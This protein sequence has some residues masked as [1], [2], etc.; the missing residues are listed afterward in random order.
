MHIYDRMERKMAKAWKNG[1]KLS[2]WSCS[3]SLETVTRTFAKARAS[4]CAAIVTRIFSSFFTRQRL[5]ASIPVSSFHSFQQ[6]FVP[7]YDL[8]A[9]T[10]THTRLNIDF[11]FFLFFASIDITSKNIYIRR[12]ILTYSEY[13]WVLL[14][15]LL[16]KYIS[17]PVD[18][19]EFS[20]LLDRQYWL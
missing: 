17:I 5:L 4:K 16:D 2:K 18:S 15:V 19:L 13:F 14:E 6:F 20:L 10:E 9:K 7:F 8:K 11:F 12:E 1:E 3:R